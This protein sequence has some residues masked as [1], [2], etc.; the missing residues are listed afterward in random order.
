M[1]LYT[2]RLSTFFIPVLTYVEQQLAATDA[3]EPDH[4]K[5]EVLQR[6]ELAQTQALAASYSSEDA[7]QALFATV[8][9][10]DEKTMT[11]S[12]QGAMAWRLGPLQQHYFDTNKAGIEFFQRLQALGLK[13]AAVK[14]VYAAVLTAGFKGQYSGK[15]HQIT[16]P[17]IRSALEDLKGQRAISSWSPSEPLFF[18]HPHLNKSYA[19]QFRRQR[20]QPTLTLLILLGVP[21]FTLIAVFIYF[22]ISLGQLVTTLTERE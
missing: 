2:Q 8:A 16:S 18:S 3:L 19:A 14:E 9:W 6:L 13:Q 7:R 1:E 22:D 21:I 20:Y 17:Q 11:S 4:F 5:Q 10:I 15:G 12:W